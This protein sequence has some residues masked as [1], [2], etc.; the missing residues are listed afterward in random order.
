MNGA[1]GEV[2]AW[3]FGVAFP[4]SWAFHYWGR[5]VQLL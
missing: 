1:E 2:K 5:V 4:E 3:P